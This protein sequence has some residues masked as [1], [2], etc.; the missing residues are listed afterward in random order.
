MVDYYYFQFSG[1]NSKY[2]NINWNSLISFF[3]LQDI[4]HHGFPQTFVFLLS[5]PHLYRHP[6]RNAF[7]F[8]AT[9]YLFWWEHVLW[10]L[11]WSIS[12]YLLCNRETAVFLSDSL[13][14]ILIWFPFSLKHHSCLRASFMVI[15]GSFYRITFFSGLI[16]SLHSWSNCS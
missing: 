12:P 6:F 7:I 11:K 13:Y 15:A 8:P 14:E 2:I 1:H 3:T 9:K 5:T 16:S 4:R 10:V